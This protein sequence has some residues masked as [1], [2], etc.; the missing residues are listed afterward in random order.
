MS[1]GIAPVP[2]HQ[3]SR[4]V[5]SHVHPVRG[6]DRLWPRPLPHRTTWSRPSRFDPH[7]EDA[8]EAAH[9]AWSEG[10]DHS[11]PPAEPDFEPDWDALADLAEAQDRYEAGCLF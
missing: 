11:N 10:F 8:W 1:T 7:A 4:T 3:P 5:A 2:R 6:R 9:A